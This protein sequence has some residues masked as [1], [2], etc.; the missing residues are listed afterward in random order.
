MALGGTKNEALPG[1]V[2]DFPRHPK[3]CI[4][5]HQAGDRSQQPMQ[6]DRILSCSGEHPQQVVLVETT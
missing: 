3:Q 2:Y 4:D 5:L 6:G 1:R